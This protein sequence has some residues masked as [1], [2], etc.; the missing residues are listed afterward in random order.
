VALRLLPITAL[1]CGDKVAVH[2]PS[3]TNRDFQ[4]L[5]WLVWESGAQVIFSSLHPVGRNWWAQSINT[6]LH[7]WCHHHNFGFFDNGMAYTAP[8]LLASNGS[9]PS[10]RGKSV[11]AQGLIDRAFN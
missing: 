7:G 9:H 8:D 11:F 1:P 4:A 10:Q 5:G 6:W 3:V 2:S